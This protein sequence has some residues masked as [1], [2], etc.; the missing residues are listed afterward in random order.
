MGGSKKATIGYTYYM[1]IHMGLSRGPVNAITKI[2]A[3]GREIWRG[4]QKA[5][6]IINLDKP[7][8]FGGKKKE[9]GIVGPLQVLMGEQTQLAPA[10]LAARLGGELPGYRGVATLYYNG[11]VSAMN[12]YIKPWEIWAWRTTA[13]WDGEV[14]YPGKASITL[15][16]GNGNVIHAMNPAHIIYECLTNRD[17]GG[18]LD[19]SRIDDDA[20]RAAADALFTENFGLCIL[21]NRQGSVEDFIQVIVDHIGGALRQSRFDGLLGLKLIRDDYDAENIPLFDEDSGLISIENDENAAADGGINEIIIKWE[22]PVTGNARQWRERN[23]AAIA[24]AGQI[25]S[26]TTEYP[27]LPTGA[28]AGRIALRDLT[29]RA[30]TLKRFTVKLDRRAYRLQPGDVFRLKSLRRGLEN[31]IVRAGRVEDGTLDNGAITITAVQDIFGLPAAAISALPPVEWT[32]PDRAP[33]PLLTRRIIE[34][35]WRDLAIQIDAANLELLRTQYGEAAYLGILA[36]QPTGLSLGYQVQT[37]VGG[38]AWDEQNDGDFTATGIC[39]VELP[40]S[41]AVTPFTVTDGN[42]LERFTAGAALLID[43]EICRIVAWNPATAAGTLARGCADTVPAPHIP[44][45]RVWLLDENC[46]PEVAWTTGTSVQTRLLTKTSAGALDPEQAPVSSI[47]L[48]A[49]QARPYP[50][51]NFKINGAAYPATVPG[52]TLRL[53]YGFDASSL[54]P[55]G[56]GY[57]NFIITASDAPAWMFWEFSR[58]EPLMSIRVRGGVVGE[59]MSLA[60]WLNG[61]EIHYTNDDPFGAPDWINTGVTISGIDDSGAYFTLPVPV[62]ACRGVRLYRAQGRIGVW[63]GDY[64][65]GG[66]LFYSASQAVTITWSHRDRIVQADQL[67]DTAMGAIGPE[68]GTTYRVRLYSPAD[69]LRRVYSGIT[70]TSQSYSVADEVADGGPFTALRIVLDSQRDGIDSHQAHDWTVTRG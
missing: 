1:G 62:A 47:T 68:P 70:G 9:G 66:I 24:S 37:R 35:N 29:V 63:G 56:S 21:W 14:W 38:G 69:T 45:A 49:R 23:L 17:W 33:H 12:P 52:G 8:L 7:N 48:A 54:D 32:P 11:Q 44:E 6:G 15:D 16:D 19:R 39:T 64:D 10:A 26:E 61:C 18:G 67:I 50:P 22:D 43:N 46:A 2:M 31:I 41:A 58:S 5:S 53:P 65:S 4:E 30:N 57:G 60:D 25:I 36:A 59:A 27:G 42:G 13:G 40:Q 28:L 20:F 51:G 34:L 55:A 3:G